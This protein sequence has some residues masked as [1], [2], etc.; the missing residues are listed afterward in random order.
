MHREKKSVIPD[1]DRPANSSLWS[2]KPG[3]EGI[4]FELRQ[5]RSF[6]SDKKQIDPIV[7][8]YNNY[9]LLPIDQRFLVAVPGTKAPGLL[10]P[11]LE[12]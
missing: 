8:L 4:I 2:K 5:A 6:N 11:V 12:K 1:I 3:E 7:D 9:K 10:D